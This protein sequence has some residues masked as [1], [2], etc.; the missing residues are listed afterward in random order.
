[1]TVALAEMSEEQILA[2]AEAVHRRELEAGAEKLRIAYQWAV[3]HNPE[4][5][6]R[7]AD[8]PGRERAKQLGGPG[9]PK[10]T[11]YAAAT[12]GARLGMSP[13]AAQMLIADA[14]DL[15]LRHPALAARVEACEVKASYARHVAGRT[16]ELT[17]DEAAFVDNEVAESADGRIPWSRFEALV[18]GKVAAAAPELARRR[19]EQ[20]AKATFAKKVRGEGHGMASFLVRADVATIEQLDATVTA[21]AKR[22]VETMADATED[23]RRVQAVRLLAHPGAD[24]AQTDLRDLSPTVQLHLHVFPD[25]DGIARLEGHGPVTEA[26]IAK[27]LSPR[28]RFKVTPVLDVAG[29]APVDAYEIPARHRTAVHCLTPADVF[30][31]GANTSRRMEIDH[32]HAWSEGGRSEVGNYGPMTRRHHRIKTHG[33]WVVRQ[34]FPGIYLWRDPYGAYYLVDHTGTRRLGDADPDPPPLGHLSAGEIYLTQFA[35]EYAPN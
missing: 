8:R 17:A 2:H 5:L 31:F 19:E 32:T 12:L 4:R 33:D 1:M 7:T 30:P 27:V 35:L 22:L 3:I 20:A 16:R 28:C 10:V 34:P 6:D 18:D 23:D 21:V 26:W 13:F 25:G 11:E 24:A 9:T 29:Q 14:L 15:Y